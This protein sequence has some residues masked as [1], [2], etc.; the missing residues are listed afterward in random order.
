MK[1]FMTAV[2]SVAVS[3]VALAVP[4]PVVSGPCARPMA[5]QGDLNRADAGR[6]A[7]EHFDLMD[8]DHNGVLTVAERQ[9]RRDAMKAQCPRAGKQQASGPKGDGRGP[10]MQADISKADFVQ[11]AEQMFDRMD[12]DRNGVVTQAERKSWQQ[13]KRA[14][15]QQRRGGGAPVDEPLW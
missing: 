9:A 15:H 1:I 6:L 4:A 7:G 3:A 14:A 13:Q 8:A 10:R 5:M 2:I 11:R 12:A